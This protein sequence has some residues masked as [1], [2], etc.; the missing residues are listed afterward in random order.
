MYINNL[1]LFLTLSKFFATLIFHGQNSRFKSLKNIPFYELS[2]FLDHIFG[3]TSRKKMQQVVNEIPS[4]RKSGHITVKFTP[5]VFPTAA[6]ESQEDEEKE[7]NNNNNK[8]FSWLFYFCM[9][10]VACG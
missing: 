3:F 7:V 5:R 10:L 4:P 9:F 6:R 8:D 1:D 2:K